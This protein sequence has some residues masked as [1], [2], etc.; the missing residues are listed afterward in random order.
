M[1]SVKEISPCGGGI[2]SNAPYAIALPAHR[3]CNVDHLTPARR[4]F[5]ATMLRMGPSAGVTPH[6]LSPANALRHSHISVH[7]QTPSPPTSSWGE[8]VGVRWVRISVHTP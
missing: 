3:F 8:R 7:A 5:R 1:V 2:M 4:L 6:D